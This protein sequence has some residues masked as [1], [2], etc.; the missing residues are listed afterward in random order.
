MK[1]IKCGCKATATVIFGQAIH[2]IC[3]HCGWSFSVCDHGPA[4]PEE[5]NQLQGDQFRQAITTGIYKPFRFRGYLNKNNINLTAKNVNLYN[6]IM[7]YSDTGYK[8]V[9]VP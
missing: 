2:Y 4:S 3:E 8:K 1:C 6:P 5:I 9:V 7:E